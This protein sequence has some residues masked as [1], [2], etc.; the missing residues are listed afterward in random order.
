MPRRT[1]VPRNSRKTACLLRCESYIGYKSA[2]QCSE[3]L[4][5]PVYTRTPRPHLASDLSFS[6]PRWLWGAPS[7]PPAS[8]TIFRWSSSSARRSSIPAFVKSSVRRSPAMRSL[9]A[10]YSVCTRIVAVSSSSVYS[11]QLG[12]IFTPIMASSSLSCGDLQRSPAWSRACPLSRSGNI[13]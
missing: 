10:P 9:S 6:R 11:F 8:A 2:S 1:G 12:L 4:R 5:R 13:T 3:S 7:L